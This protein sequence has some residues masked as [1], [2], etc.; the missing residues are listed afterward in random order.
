MQGLHIRTFNLED[1]CAHVLMN[2]L[3]SLR[4]SDKMLGLPSIYRF[5]RNEFN[6]FN[7]TRARIMLDSIY[8][9]TLS[10]IS[11]VK[12][13]KCAIMYATLLWMSLRFQ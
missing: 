3:N 1:L 2:I 9:M 7:N 4:K 8:Y 12:R 11:G 10:L 6:K 13:Y 5:F